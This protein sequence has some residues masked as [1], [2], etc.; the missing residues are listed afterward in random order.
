MEVAPNTLVARGFNAEVEINNAA[1]RK[2]VP[3]LEDGTLTVDELFKLLPDLRTERVGIWWWLVD[4]EAVIKEAQVYAWDE[5][6]ISADLAQLWQAEFDEGENTSYSFS[7][8]LVLIGHRPQ[9]W[10]PEDNPEEPTGM[11]KS[12][13]DPNTWPNV[14]LVE[15]L[16]LDGTETWQSLPTSLTVQV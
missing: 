4:D 11:G 15:I 9:G 2:L 8:P 12:Y 16:Y 14:T 3:H 7:L 13:I 1:E 6:T 5:E 10:D